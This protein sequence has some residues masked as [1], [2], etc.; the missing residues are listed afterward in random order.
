MKTPSKINFI[1]IALYLYLLLR[2]HSNKCHHI[3]PR[4]LCPPY[5]QAHPIPP[6]PIPLA[7]LLLPLGLTLQDS[8]LSLPL[9]DA[10][11]LICCGKSIK[12]FPAKYIYR[13]RSLYAKY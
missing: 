1:M 3:H 2:F 12:L 9:V 4:L 10:P 11:K 7:G 6:L 13:V 5:Q 8:I